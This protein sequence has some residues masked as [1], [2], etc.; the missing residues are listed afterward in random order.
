MTGQRR[1]LLI[2]PR[3]FGYEQDIAR[4][5]G[6]AGFAV[7]LVD[8]RPSN[9]AL[10][11]AALRLRAS[12]L[13][14]IVRRYYD[15]LVERGLTR[16]YDLVL[17]IKGE[18]VPDWFLAR[19]RADSPLATMAFYTFDSLS[20]SANFVELLHHFEH[21]YS[22][23]PGATAVDP[24]FR[25]KHLFFAPEF[26]PLDGNA[27]RKY[28]VAFIGTLHSDRYRYVKRLMAGFAHTY[29]YF[30]VQAPWYFRVR[31]FTSARFRE[32]APG[33][34]S[35]A[36]LDRAAVAHVFRESRAVLDMQHEDQIGL[37]MRTFEAIASGAYLV[38]SNRY[39]QETE[40]MGTGRVIV[41][42]DELDLPASLAELPETSG[43]PDGFE[44]YSL[45]S[46]VREFADLVPGSSS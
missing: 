19:V 45:A 43:A 14:R 27:E 15:G 8:E 23:Q 13:T 37:T 4:E 18:V 12:L 35:F 41:A 3:F 32:V 34:V 25:L 7:D 46:W 39:I 28:D 5:F 38:T 2:S 16:D 17:V 11:K 42:D 6:R 26:R 36:K 10:A 1:M 33:D 24:R 20:N 21:L 22:F 30:Y 44:R 29:A 9:S 40:I 31:R